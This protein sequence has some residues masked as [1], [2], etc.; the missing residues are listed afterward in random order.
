VDAHNCLER[1]ALA[2]GDVNYR[3]EQMKAHRALSGLI[4]D[5]LSFFEHKPGIVAHELDAKTQEHQFTRA[6]TLR[7]FPSI[8]P[9][10]HIHQCFVVDEA[11]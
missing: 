7:G 10:V 1:A 2:I 4:E 9:A 6:V 3:L 5:D 11:G 8:D